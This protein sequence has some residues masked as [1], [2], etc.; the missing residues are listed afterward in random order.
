MYAGGLGGASELWH[1]LLDASLPAVNLAA[2]SP[3]PQREFMRELRRMGRPGR[4]PGDTVDG[5]GSAR[6]RC[7]R[8]LS[9]C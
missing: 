6:S 8:T 9:C 1:R 4:A 5:P 3:L 7:A 2:P